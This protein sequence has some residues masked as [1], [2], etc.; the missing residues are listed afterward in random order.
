MQLSITGHHIDVTERFATSRDEGKFERLT[1]RSTH[2]QRAV[3]C[4]WKTHPQGRRRFRAAR[5][6]ADATADVKHASIDALIDKLDQQIVKRKEKMQGAR[7]L[8]FDG[9]A[10]HR[11]LR[12]LRI[13]G[14]LQQPRRDC[15]A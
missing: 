6:I 7:R 9:L 10:R 11:S 14:V 13:G 3:G 1:R 5:V 15:L 2:H 12:K 4:P 8:E